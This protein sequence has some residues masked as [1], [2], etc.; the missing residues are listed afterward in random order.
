MKV[1]RYF[2]VLALLCTSLCANAASLSLLYTGDN[3]L[4]EDGAVLATAGEVLLFELRM[5]FSGT[6]VLG[7]VELP[8][9]TIGGGYDIEFD[10]QGFRDVEFMSAALGNPDFYRVPE[11]LTGLLQNGAFGD[12]DGLSGPAT[13][14]WIAFSA[15]DTLGKFDITPIGGNSLFDEFISAVTFIDVLDVDYHGAAVRVVPLPAAGW[16]M[17]SGLIALYWKGRGSGLNARTAI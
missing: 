6:Q 2:S 9:I 8:E 3:A 17:L 12:I 15:G 4:D 13:V 5:D 7:G 14:G 11:L 16:C 1:N 10:A